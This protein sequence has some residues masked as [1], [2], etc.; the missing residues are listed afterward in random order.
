MK[1]AVY[2]KYG[3]PDVVQITDIEKPVPKDN[4]ILIKVCAASVNPYD[5]HFIVP[6][7]RRNCYGIHRSRTHGEGRKYDDDGRL[8]L[9]QILHELFSR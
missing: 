9:V 6:R 5:W 3:P 1:A 7:S 4:E 8:R 2:T